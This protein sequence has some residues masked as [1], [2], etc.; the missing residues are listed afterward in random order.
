MTSSIAAPP[1]GV[2]TWFLP[3]RGAG[4]LEWAKY[5]GFEAVHFDRNDLAVGTPA[6]F[7]SAADALGVNLAGLSVVEIE[8]LGIAG[9]EVRDAVT[10]AIDM[11]VHLSVTFVYL[12]AFGAAALRDGEALS[13]MANLL[14][15]AVKSAEGTSLTVATEN[16]LDSKELLTLFSL[17]SG[18][19]VELLFDTQNPV[20][21]GLDPLTLIEMAGHHVKT[22][23]H[24]KDGV[25]E[26]GDCRIGDGCARVS[27]SI[28]ALVNAG[29]DGTF[30]LES[31]YRTGNIQAARLDQ[32]RVRQFAEQRERSAR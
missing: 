9:R 3:R 2:T 13:L 5:A 18:D 20:M 26:L 28:G 1:L 10:A 27:E 12:P 8:H 21:V 11:A 24:V 30:V 16:D 6:G 17:L 7:R 15:H 4:A 29:F 19:R 14:E 25:Y 32:N 23:A 22:F 31:D